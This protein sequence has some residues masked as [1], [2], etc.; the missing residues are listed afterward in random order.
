[1]VRGLCPPTVWTSHLIYIKGAFGWKA[2]CAT[3]LSQ[4]FLKVLLSTIMSRN[5]HIWHTVSYYNPGFFMK[6]PPSAVLSTVIILYK[7]TH[8]YVKLVYRLTN[9][10]TKAN[11]HFFTV[12]TLKVT[13]LTRQGN[14][15]WFGWSKSIAW[16][17]ISFDLRSLPHDC[18]I[19]IKPCLCPTRCFRWRY[20]KSCS[21]IART[22]SVMSKGSWPT[23][24]VTS[25][26]TAI[27]N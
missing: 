14:G 23:G 12:L 10:G 20:L 5:E 4:Y 8:S 13:N 16:M 22:C 27:Q 1:M 9:T 21:Q 24:W 19:P 2:I 15:L 6:W 25:H 11:S 18:S 26:H 3:S 7:C 17:N